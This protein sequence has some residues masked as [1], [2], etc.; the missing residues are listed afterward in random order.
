M[1]SFCYR[2]RYRGGLA[3]GYPFDLL[4]YLSCVW[5]NNQAV[6]AHAV[7]AIEYWV[8]GLGIEF[9]YRFFY[10]FFVDI[11]CRIIWEWMHSYLFTLAVRDFSIFERLPWDCSLLDWGVGIILCGYSPIGQRFI[12]TRLKFPRSTHKVF[13]LL[14]R[15]SS[16]VNRCRILSSHSESSR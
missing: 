12:T 5:L 8:K 6:V 16:A 1:F 2:D 10:I 4:P 9:R 14:G 3:V 15:K 11:F 13:I 7:K